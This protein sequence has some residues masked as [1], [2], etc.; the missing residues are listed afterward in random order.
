MCEAMDALRRRGLTSLWRGAFGR[1]TESGVDV[2]MTAVTD[3]TVAGYRLV[4]GDR[5]NGSSEPRDRAT[6][7]DV[8]P[9][10]RRSPPLLES[11][12]C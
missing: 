11:W 10:A 4:A 8:S 2:G 3:L 7:M 9:L 1:Q 12:W 5:G 6:S